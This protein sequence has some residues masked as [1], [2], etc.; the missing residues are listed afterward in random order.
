MADVI[1][2]DLDDRAVPRSKVIIVPAGLDETVRRPDGTWERRIAAT[3][4]MQKIAARNP[5]DG[6]LLWSVANGIALEGPQAEWFI[7]AARAAYEAGPAPASMRERRELYTRL[8][9]LIDRVTTAP[10]G[11]GDAIVV[12]TAVAEVVR[13]AF[14]L[15]GRWPPSPERMVD[16]AGEVSADLAALVRMTLTAPS[17]PARRIAF[18]R[19]AEHVRAMTGETD[20]AAVESRRTPKGALW[21]FLLPFR[22]L[23]DLVR[24][25]SGGP[26]FGD[27]YRALR[28]LRRHWRIPVGIAVRELAASVPAWTIPFCLGLVAYSAVRLDVAGVLIGIGL[29]AT[30]SI[31]AGVLEVVLVAYQSAAVER[32]WTLWMLRIAKRFLHADLG[33]FAPGE[34]VFR[35]E[36]AEATFH[37][38]LDCVLRAIR[39]IWWVL[40]FPLFLLLAPPV[41]VVHIVLTAL[42]LAGLY[43][44]MSVLVYRYALGI[45]NLRGR[46]TAR[47]TEALTG[48]LW[49]RAFRATDTAIRRVWQEAE[50]LRERVVAFTIIQTA[51][52]TVIGLVIRL[53]PL[54]LV[55]EAVMLV[56]AGQLS[57]YAAVAIGGWF[58]FALGPVREFLDLGPLLARGTARAR[59][60]LEAYGQAS[61]ARRR[62]KRPFPAGRR[63]R[64]A[65]S[66]APTPWGTSGVVVEYRR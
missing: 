12:P 2:V 35:F 59:R 61:P 20:G 39:L 32:L 16:R 56:K 53:A 14:R 36:D 9:E 55:A 64:I 8:T 62:G 17:T 41:F 29:A 33:R 15:S 47:L 18:R 52:E 30:A 11:T 19:L 38:V 1:G 26:V 45:A 24:W 3:D 49:L 27:F 51:I 54:V 10:T 7:K 65:A 21:A 34:L 25:L 13:A 66:F 50:P 5:E 48:A 40:P 31:V 43:A 28:L 42:V 22:L 37:A 23:Q 6:Y 60:F 4:F 63:L 58:A 44:A 57:P 46:L